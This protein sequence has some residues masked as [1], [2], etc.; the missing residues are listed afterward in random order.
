MRLNKRILAGALPAI[1]LL[2]ASCGSTSE[3]TQ[4]ISFSPKVNSLYIPDNMMEDVTCQT[5]MTYGIS[6]DLIKRTM[7]LQCNELR[8]GGK[9]LSFTT[10][11]MPMDYLMNGVMW[12]AYVKNG[13]AT[14]AGNAEV[15]N[16]NGYVTNI[17]QYYKPTLGEPLAGNVVSPLPFITYH[18]NDYI[19]KT[20]A[21]NSY[22]AGETVTQYPT[23]GGQE[24]FKNSDPIYRVQFSSDMKKADV[25][26]YKA[27]F[28]K[29][30]K[31]KGIV[32][33]GIYVKGLDVKL[34]RSGY[35]LSGT[36]IIPESLGDGGALLP[37]ER[38]K[39]DS[40]NIRTVNGDMSQISCDYVVA[41]VFRGTF[42]GYSVQRIL[43]N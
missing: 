7:I 15:S 23:E 31:D 13:A 14:G 12:T 1:A 30:M 27:C 4:T 34:T 10:D 38:Y 2:A 43:N 24:T 22:F 5:G 20:F 11:A 36:D 39:F 8:V 17:V 18:V 40:I 35:E 21:E 42:T 3:P 33:E 28:A 19:V 25:V 29:S 16:L 6:M 9:N 32:L 41:S 26:I 37:Y